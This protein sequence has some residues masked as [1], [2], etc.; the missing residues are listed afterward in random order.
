MVTLTVAR[1]FH[2][3]LSDSTGVFEI[4]YKILGHPGH[5]RGKQNIFRR[6]INL[7]NLLVIIYDKRITN[8]DRS[9]GGTDKECVPD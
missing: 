9:Y 4:V 3:V 1:V 8:I 7:G 2:A 6:I 5:V